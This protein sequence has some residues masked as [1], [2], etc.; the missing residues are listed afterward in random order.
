MTHS[1]SPP[2]REEK[3]MNLMMNHAIIFTSMFEGV[4]TEVAVK[5]SEV[6]VGM[7]DMIADAMSPGTSEVS[8]GTAVAKRRVEKVKPETGPQVSG[9]IKQAFSGI[10][11]EMSA[12]MAEN[13][14][15][16]GAYF[17]DPD[18]DRGI[19]IVERYD[20]GLPKLTEKL[21]DED[22]ASYVVLLKSGDARLG[23]MFQEL[24][25]WQESMPKPPGRE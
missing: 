23:E 13:D 10:R 25:H 15:E 9:G 22:L 6:M 17:A 18:F 3:A 19:A 2:I 21:S 5:M 7:G 24:G 16:F 14:A 20:F 12:K 8:E 4:F 1:E 11:K